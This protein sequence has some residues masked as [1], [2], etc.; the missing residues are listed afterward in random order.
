MLWH[1]I[2]VVYTL[3]QGGS[4]SEHCINSNDQFRNGWVTPSFEQ[5]KL[6]PR[7]LWNFN[8]REIISV[9]VR[10]LS[11]KINLRL[12]LLATILSPQ[13]KVCLSTEPLQKKSGER[14]IK[15]EYISWTPC[16]WLR[17]MYWVFIREPFMLFDLA[18]LNLVFV[19][20]NNTYTILT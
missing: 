14:E 13:E 12:E 2:A 9:R 1:L 7:F 20:Y 17:S 15:A 6:S 19:S 10:E 3:V 4:W 16:F 11:K 5:H 8:R 18:N